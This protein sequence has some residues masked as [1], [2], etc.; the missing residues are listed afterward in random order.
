MA[1]DDDRQDISSTFVQPFLFYI[2]KTLTSFG[3]N[4]ESA[5]DWEMEQ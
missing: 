4:S 1:G 5:Y 2:T 3:M